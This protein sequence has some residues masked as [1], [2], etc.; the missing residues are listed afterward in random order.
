MC[1]FNMGTNLYLGGMPDGSVGSVK[2]TFGPADFSKFFK[3]YLFFTN[4]IKASFNN[5]FYD[6]S[7][8]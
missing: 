6:F 4:Y 7:Y 5:Q 1:W 8:D 3:F 2:A